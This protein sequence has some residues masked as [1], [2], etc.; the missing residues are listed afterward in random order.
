M[1]LTLQALLDEGSRTLFDA[2]IGEA[3]LDAKLLLFEAFGTDMTH[4]IMDR[5]TRLG[6]GDSVERAVA[7]YRAMIVR[8]SK[9][10]PLQQ[11]MGS[12]E[13]MGLEFYVNEHV[14]IPRQDTETLV[15][16]VL[17]DFKGQDK[18][19]LDMCAGS[20][21]IGLSLLALGGYNSVTEADISLEALK[22][23]KRNAKQVMEAK[24]NPVKIEPQRLTEQPW[25]MVIEGRLLDS[26]ISVK[27]AASVCR[28]TLV[29]SDLFSSFT[30]KW[31]ERFDII[32][33]NPPYIPSAVIEGLE[34]EVKDHE[35]RLALDGSEDGLV[36]Y[37]RLA[38]E[39]PAYLNPGG[40][41]YLEIGYDQGEAV[42]G[43]LKEAGFEGVCVIKDAPGL[44]R[45]VK[46][47][48]C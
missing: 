22:V 29:E 48:W 41:V 26:G 42:S 31:Q 14:L 10:V 40:A 3:V 43:L 38:R 18:K 44:D 8:R 2:G 17:K 12:S 39:C 30:G 35:P 16:E 4:F 46:G 28:V 15:E 11:I 7:D 47:I 5:N 13:F 23:T 24:M 45:V 27:P 33:S 1:N 34:P 20:G 9:R 25:R 32:V 36:F 21:C 6:D 37:R 19:V